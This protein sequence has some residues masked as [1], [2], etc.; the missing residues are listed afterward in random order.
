M[1]ASNYFEELQKKITGHPGKP[2]FDALKVYDMSKFI[3]D[4]NSSQLRQ[5]ICLLEDRKDPAQISGID[6]RS[7]LQW[8]FGDVNRNFH[9]FLTAIATLV[10]H[11][12]NLMKKNFVKPE[13]RAEYQIKVEAIFASDPLAQF[14][15]KC[16]NYITHYAIPQIGLEE[17][18][19]LTGAG[20]ESIELFIDLDH[21]ETSFDWSAPSRQF[22]ESNRP[23]IR[24]LKLV[25]DYELK[26]KSFYSEL[27]L[28]FEK[29]LGRELSEVRSMMQESNNLWEQ[30]TGV[31]HG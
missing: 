2:V 11:S 28:T 24:M 7:H 19:G 30:M 14:L 1:N 15:K 31:K 3:L 10:D 22:I 6:R 27:M 29:H 20:V 8:L 13:H 9:N 5:L 17:Q 26:S 16:R 25:D 21:L 23:Q 12:R 4:G 18:F